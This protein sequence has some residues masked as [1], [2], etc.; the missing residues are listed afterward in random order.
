MHPGVYG[1]GSPALRSNHSSGAPHEGLVAIRHPRQHCWIAGRGDAVGRRGARRR[2]GVAVDVVRL[3]RHVRPEAFASPQPRN[4]P[5]FYAA[6]AGQIL[7]A[8]SVVLAG[9]DHLLGVLTECVQVLAGI[10]LPSAVLFL[11]MLFDVRKLRVHG[12]ARLL[13]GLE[14][15]G[16]LVDP[17]DT[18]CRSVCR[19]V[20]KIRHAVRAHACREP[21][22]HGAHARVQPQSSLCSTIRTP[23]PPA[24][25]R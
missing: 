10:L 19:R 12:L 2:R 1:T 15:R 17:D 24:R 9:S 25:N 18:W 20:G 14:G 5:A 11:V 23:R 6:Y 7:L 22:R 21:E 8:S 3:W 13:G 4:A 16:S